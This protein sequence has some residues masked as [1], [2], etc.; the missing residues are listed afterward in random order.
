MQTLRE[1]A[2]ALWTIF[3]ESHS[4]IQLESF[5]GC[6][7][8]PFS[9][10]YGEWGERPNAADP[11]E[12]YY[13]CHL[14]DVQKIWGENPRCTAENWRNKAATEIEVIANFDIQQEIVEE[15]AA[16]LLNEFYQALKDEANG[17]LP[18]NQIKEKLFTGVDPRVI[19]AFERKLRPFRDISLRAYQARNTTNE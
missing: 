1:K 8:C 4:P 5:A 18:L 16:I 14:L 7:R 12:G 19:A 2:P 9:E 10:E 17:D 13:N 3:F 6:A 11:D 15:K